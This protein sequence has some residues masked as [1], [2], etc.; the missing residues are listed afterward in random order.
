MIFHRKQTPIIFLYTLNGSP[1]ER[2]YSVKDLG[3]YLVPSLSF[4]QHINIT[5]GR[6]LKVLGFIKRNTSLSTSITCLRPL[7]FSLVRSISEYGMVVWHPYL[8]KDQLHLEQVQ[9][10]FLS[11]VAFLLKIDHPPRLPMTIHPSDLP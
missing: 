8:G 11:C 9:N 10:R 1:L 3:I 7:Y 5:V 2:V 4:E 6:A